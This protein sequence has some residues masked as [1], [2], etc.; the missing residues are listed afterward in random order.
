MNFTQ[1]QQ[2][3]FDKF[4]EF[5]DST[6]KVFILN[7]Y[8]GTGKTTMIKYFTEHLKSIS[9]DYQLMAPTGRAAKVLRDKVGE[10]YT[11]HKTI[12][13]YSDLQCLKTEAKDDSEKSYHFVF[14]VRMTCMEPILPKVAIID[15]SSMISDTASHHEFFSFGSG[16]L[17]SDLLQYAANVGIG[18][19]VFVGDNAQLP[20]VTDNHSSALDPNYFKDLG[21]TVM[22]AEMKNVV[23]QTNESGILQTANEIRTLLK[24]PLKERSFFTIEPNGSDMIELDCSGI[25]D[26]YLEM[27][28]KP[29]FGNGVIINYSNAQ[30]YMSNSIIRERMYGNKCDVKE[31]DI[32]LINNNNYHTFGKEI[33]NGD[34]ARVIEVGAKEDAQIPVTRNGERKV[35]KLEFKH[36]TLLFPDSDIPIKCIVYYPLLFN[37]D[38]EITAWEQQALYIYFKIRNPKL[39]EGSEEFKDALK[40]DLYFNV[41]KVKFG[42][43]I[44]CHKAQGGEWDNVIVDYS[45]RTGTNDDMLRWCYT[46]TTRAKERLY[47]LFP[48]QVTPFSKLKILVLPTNA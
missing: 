2:A 35:V 34:M 39:K 25:Y 45:M 19:L 33:F 23:R 21:T 15:E 38:A 41:L 46:A 44:T 42:Y 3:A 18:K 43:A 10:A 28:P 17:L 12:Y 6:A 8:A 27:F 11:I 4:I 13:N 14:P 32:L 36:L 7:G 40:K 9:F 5:L 24:K 20:P 48:P 26:K 1:D 47:M 16:K 31:G 37:R 29:K 22:T 30:C